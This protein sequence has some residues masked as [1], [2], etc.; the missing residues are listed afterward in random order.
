MVT[1]P[2]VMVI[3]QKATEAAAR[4]IPEG[5]AHVLVG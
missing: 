5:K 3:V 4:H 2:G 1:Q